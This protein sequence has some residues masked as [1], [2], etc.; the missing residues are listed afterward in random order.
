M[1]HTSYGSLALVYDRLMRDAPY[2]RWLHWTEAMWRRAHVEPD[3]VVDLACGT[4]VLTWLL[5]KTGRRVFGVD[6][7]SDMLAVAANK[8]EQ[9]RDVCSQVVWMEQD[10]RELRLPHPVDAVVCYCD[11]LNYLLTAA[12]WQQTFQAVYRALRPSGVFLFDIHSEHKLSHV[13]G[14]ERYVWEEEGIYCAWQNQFDEASGIVDE[15]LTLFVERDDG[16]YERL[17][18]LHRQRTFPAETVKRWLKN[19]GFMV[20][21]ATADFREDGHPEERSERLFFNAQKQV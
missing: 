10:M 14:N 11:S 12:D 19:T 20:L 6:R 7:S 13:F 17:D 8:A 3:A 4:G 5:A 1:T 18:E 16:R 9:H 21:S 2:D 15:A